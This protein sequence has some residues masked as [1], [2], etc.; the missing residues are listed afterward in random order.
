ML[1]LSKPMVTV[2]V[3]VKNSALTIR[4]TIESIISQDYPHELME[5]IVV[6]GYSSDGTVDIIKK[7]LLNS[8]IKTRIFYENKGLGYA[9][10]IVVNNSIGD[11]IIWVDGDMI[12]PR[13]FITKQV[14]FMLKNPKVG[15]AKARYSIAEKENLVSYL[16]NVEFVVAFN[17]TK[18]S[19]FRVLGTSGCI[20]RSSALKHVRGFDTKIRGVG[21]DMDIEYRLRRAGWKLCISSASFYEKRRR[22]WQELWEEYRWHGKGGAYI[23]K[24][25]GKNA[26]LFPRKSLFEILFSKLIDSILAYRLLHHKK[27]FLLPLHYMFKRIAWIYGF[28]EGYLGSSV[29]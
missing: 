21:E 3:C 27:V 8:D 9:R 17:N 10:Q 16:E 1:F 20:Y 12:L 5:I 29:Q 23:F 2:G 28:L 15:V 4:E 13:N 22:T 19:Q 18:N 14:D 6:D 7:I 25:Y 24:K 11:Y 26:D